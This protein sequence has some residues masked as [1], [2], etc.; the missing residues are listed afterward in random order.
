MPSP[1]PLT[2]PHRPELSEA[3]YRAF[4]STFV[5]LLATFPAPLS[6]RPER[7]ALS[8][9]VVRLREAANS[10]L[11]RADEFL[12][13]LALDR[14]EFELVWRQVQVSIR[15]N[16]VVIAKPEVATNISRALIASTEVPK[17]TFTVTSPTLDELSAF[18]SVFLRRAC[19]EPVLFV[20]DV[21]E[22]IPPV[23]VAFEQTPDG[24]MML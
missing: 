12:A 3:K 18:A 14:A 2:N 24:W 21:P 4:E 5:D 23:G 13:P 10:L 7:G 15:G 1:R 9:L 20:G 19:A 8:S 17:L 22:F 16:V 11:F 6:L